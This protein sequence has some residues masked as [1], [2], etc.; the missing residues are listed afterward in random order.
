MGKFALP[1]LEWISIPNGNL[2]LETLDSP[3]TYHISAFS[4]SKYPITYE[5][6]QSFID[7][8]GYQEDRWWRGLAWRATTPAEATWPIY[9][10]PREMVSWYEAIAFTRWLSVKFK[11][12]VTLPTE[13]QWQYAAA[14]D[15]DQEYPWGTYFDQNKCNTEESKVQQTTPVVQYLLGASPYGVM[16]MSG[17]VWEWM[18]TEYDNPDSI[19]VD[20]DGI[21]GDSYRT[22]RGGSWQE[23]FELAR[24][25]VR[26]REHPSVRLNDIGFRVAVISP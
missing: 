24:V 2:R 21:G 9:N 15:R 14:S 13:M 23:N 11:R 16:D 5:Q 1:L 8:G 25:T 22:L 10:H 18:S 12:N 20:G 19:S 3:K 17:N 4:M 6:F 26:L 7:D